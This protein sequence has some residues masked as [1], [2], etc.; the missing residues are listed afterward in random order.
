MI[1]SRDSEAV[2]RAELTS[3]LIKKDHALV[4]ID[5]LIR[6]ALDARN[7]ASELH[8]VEVRNVSNRHNACI[9]DN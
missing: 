1:K 8:S 5:M 9:T 3:L 7:M 6:M 2:A 4:V